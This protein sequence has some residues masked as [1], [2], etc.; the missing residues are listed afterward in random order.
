MKFRCIASLLGMFL[1]TI[2]ILFQQTF[3]SEFQVSEMFANRPLDIRV[4]GRSQICP[5]RHQNHNAEQEPE[6]GC[7][8]TASPNFV[9]RTVEKVMSR[10]NIFV[11]FDIFHDKVICT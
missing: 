11:I 3:S 4:Q 7:Q 8:E 2:Y 1:T 5:S 9:R 10:R 6:G